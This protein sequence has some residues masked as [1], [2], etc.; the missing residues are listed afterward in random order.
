M[1]EGRK[2][3]RKGT[4]MI[5]ALKCLPECSQHFNYINSEQN[6]PKGGGKGKI[7]PIWKNLPK[8]V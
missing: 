5:I 4:N 3:G 6:I 7:C 2:E 8:T 1:I